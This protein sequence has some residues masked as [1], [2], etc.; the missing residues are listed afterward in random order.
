MA[1]FIAGLLFF[2]GVLGQA[3]EIQ[4]NGI[5]AEN[6]EQHMIY[7]KAW[8]NRYVAELIGLLKMVFIIPSCI[9]VGLVFFI[10]KYFFPQYIP[11][12]LTCEVFIGLFLVAAVLYTIIKTSF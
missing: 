12:S 3:P 6:F 8:H 5:H 11:A 10:I 7:K 4:L 9:C 2:S 1:F